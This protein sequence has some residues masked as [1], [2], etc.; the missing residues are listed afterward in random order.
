MIN[1]VFFMTSS[2]LLAVNRFPSNTS[3]IMYLHKMKKKW[4]KLPVPFL[5]V[6]LVQDIRQ[7]NL[8]IELGFVHFRVKVD[9][10]RQA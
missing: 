1:L 7:L 3:L 9:L 10:Y 4:A 2:S 8:V 5:E 6:L